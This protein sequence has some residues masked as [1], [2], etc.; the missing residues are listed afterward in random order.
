[1][2]QSIVQTLSFMLRCESISWV[3]VEEGCEEFSN[4]QGLGQIRFP[5]GDISA[6]F[7]E[8]RKVLER[9]QLID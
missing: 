5:A 1:M 8:I 4:V 3:L 2:T 7:E 9:E 6:K